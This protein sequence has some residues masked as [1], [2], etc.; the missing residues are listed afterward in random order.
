MLG[1]NKML[2][3]RFIR[4]ESLSNSLYDIV[5]KYDRGQKI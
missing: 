5:M 3:A 4:T 2:D 1:C